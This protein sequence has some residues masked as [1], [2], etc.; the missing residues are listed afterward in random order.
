MI[1][2]PDTVLKFTEARRQLISG[3]TT[4]LLITASGERLEGAPRVGLAWKRSAMTVGEK[5]L[6]TVIDVTAASRNGSSPL[7]PALLQWWRE[8]ALGL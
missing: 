4:L 2:L 5:Y 3:L 7:R 1:H 6:V 8:N